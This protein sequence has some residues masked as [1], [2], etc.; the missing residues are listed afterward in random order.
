MVVV[1][2]EVEAATDLVAGYSEGRV[3][4]GKASGGRFSAIG[5]KLPSGGGLSS[6]VVSA[7]WAAAGPGGDWNKAIPVSLSF[8]GVAPPKAGGSEGSE[9]GSGGLKL[10][11]PPA[12]RLDR[13]IDA[14]RQVN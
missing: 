4:E 2:V 8:P 1:S 12:E 6:S 7:A 14:V 3:G 5:L 13:H 9:E 10:P 11:L